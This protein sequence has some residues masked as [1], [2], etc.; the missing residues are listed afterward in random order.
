[1]SKELADYLTKYTDYLA[2]VKIPMKDVA[3]SR[4]FLQPFTWDNV[5]VHKAMLMDGADLLTTC[6]NSN[7]FYS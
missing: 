1:M 6:L 3:I 7:E 5:I 2:N 4:E